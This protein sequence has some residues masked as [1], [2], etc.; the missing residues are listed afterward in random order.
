VTVEWPNVFGND[1]PV[2]VEIGPGRGDVLLAWA[3]GAPAVNFFGIEH[4]LGAAAALAEKV[5]RRGLTN[6]RVVAGDA[7]C[8]VARCVPSASVAAY[9]IYFPD[10]WPKRRH[11][12]RRLAT[13]AFAG[14]LVRTLAPGAPLHL[15]SDLRPIVE[16]FA[17]QLVEAGLVPVAGALPP[18]RPTTA[19]EQK[20]AAAGTHYVR[21][22]RPGDASTRGSGSRSCGVV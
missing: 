20:Y 4:H 8:I 1:R 18:R 15:A 12:R 5:E 10:P 9:H 6:V 17:A 22:V 14:E 16:D 11:R 7:R 21:L 3:S 19:F 2:E 13:A